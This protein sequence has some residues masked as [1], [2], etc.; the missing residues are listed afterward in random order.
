MINYWGT[1]S[2]LII[3]KQQQPHEANFLKLDISKAKNE[4]N[5]FPKWDLNLTLKHIVNWH[6]EWLNN[7]IMKDICLK[8]IDLYNTTI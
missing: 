2:K 4:L 6:K 7:S 8:E 1:D 5:W 3:D